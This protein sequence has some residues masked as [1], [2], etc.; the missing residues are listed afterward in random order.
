[1]VHVSEIPRENQR[2]RERERERERVRDR[3]RGEREKGETKTIKRV[4]CRN[5]KGDMS[6]KHANSSSRKSSIFLLIFQ[7]D[8]I[9]IF[10][11]L[12]SLSLQ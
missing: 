11:H 7:M 8:I 5:L 2:E 4:M 6:K 1:M 10:D 12:I 3:E 9:W